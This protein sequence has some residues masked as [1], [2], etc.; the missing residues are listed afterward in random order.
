MLTVNVKVY[1][2][3]E[4]IQDFIN[5]S[6]ENANGSN[7]EDGI[8]RFDII[9]NIADPKQFMLVEV[10]KTLDAPALHKE[11]EHYKKWRDTVADMMEKPR[12]NEKYSQIYTKDTN[13]EL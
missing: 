12:T 5:A 8:I 3:E 6:V 2:K 11:T 13:Y 4:N 10:Y 1:V 7:K 9:Q